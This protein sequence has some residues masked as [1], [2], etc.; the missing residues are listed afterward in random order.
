MLLLNNFFENRS[1]IAG[2][3]DRTID[4]T[5]N[6][7]TSQLTQSQNEYLRTHT[8]VNAT[9][10]AWLKQVHGDEV[11]KVDEYYYRWESFKEADA[12]ITNVPDVPLSVRTADC[13]PIFLFDKRTNA[14]GLVHAGWQG[15]QKQIAP[16]T[17]R[18]MLQ[19][20]GTEAE[21]IF[22]VLGPAIRSCCYEVGPEFE[23]HFSPDVFQR[24]GGLYLDLIKVNRLQLMDFGLERNQ[25]FDCR[26]CTACD[27]RFFS[28]RREKEKAGRM[29]SI[30][31]LKSE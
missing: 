12:L 31:M 25:I 17:C 4:F 14:I 19:E 24:N 16:N 7:K 2:I 8:G 23:K 3:S 15:S 5:F 10:L 30:M 21:D 22:V 27:E 26:I 28:Y 29:L 9:A 1:V 6:E 11:I 18:K 20:F 13:V